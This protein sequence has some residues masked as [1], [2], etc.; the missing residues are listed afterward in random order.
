MYNLTMSRTRT[1]IRLP[2]EKVAIVMRRY[3]LKTKSEAVEMALDYLVGHPMTRDEA[4]GMRGSHAVDR[5][6]EDTGPVEIDPAD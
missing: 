6:P 5:I 3:G 1:N 2:D 4:L